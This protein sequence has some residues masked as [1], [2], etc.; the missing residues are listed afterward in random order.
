MEFGH[1]QLHAG[2]GS[3][4]PREDDPPDSGRGGGAR[5][6]QEAVV[7][8]H[9][10]IGSPTGNSGKSRGALRAACGALGIRPG[11]RVGMWSTS[12][13]EWIYLQTAVARLGAV[14]VNM[15]P[16]YRV[17]DLRPIL[18]QS[19]SESAFLSREGPPRG[20]RR[21]PAG[22]WEGQRPPRSGHPIRLELGRL[23]PDDRGRPA[24]FPRSPSAPRTSST[25]STPPAPPARPRACC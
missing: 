24:S 18:R 21:D 23:G 8:C 1:A 4:D 19:G 10:G 25:S 7:S 15:N 17:V 6:D 20:L 3:P 13:V 14:L 16:A 22:A 5:P 9:Q 11:D 2:T 12:C